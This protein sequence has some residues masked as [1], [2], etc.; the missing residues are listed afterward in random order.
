MKYQKKG[1]AVLRAF[2]VEIDDKTGK[3][4]RQERVLINED[5]PFT[6]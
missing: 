5:N 1:R 3:A 6:I 4:I 2:F